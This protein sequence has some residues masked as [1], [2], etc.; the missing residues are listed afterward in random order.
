MYMNLNIFLRSIVSVFLLII[1]SGCSPSPNQFIKIAKN[2]TFEK[3]NNGIRTIEE[4]F[5][6]NPNFNV[7]W[8]TKEEG[9][10]IYIT[11]IC[12][13]SSITPNINQF[14]SF[15]NGKSDSD[16][17][18]PYEIYSA[19][20][21]FR[22]TYKSK[23]VLKFSSFIKNIGAQ[24]DFIS[25]EEYKVLVDFSGTYSFSRERFYS[26]VTSLKKLVPEKSEQLGKI[27]N[28]ARNLLE[29]RMLCWYKHGVN[30]SVEHIYNNGTMECFLLEAKKK[31]IEQT[32]KVIEHKER[33]IEDYKRLLSDEKDREIK[34]Y[35]IERLVR[36]RDG[37]E[38]ILKKH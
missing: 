26:Y 3:Y 36:E 11:A 5:N 32:K 14:K 22:F 35:V 21:R 4:A 15:L 7:K 13:D 8:E 33:E 18:T 19:E 2:T 10:Y 12:T 37:Y 1:M 30:V 17:I 31:I 25:S 34:S 20:V 6:D 23:P 29:N 9:S 24:I 16:K 38:E 28:E 27:D